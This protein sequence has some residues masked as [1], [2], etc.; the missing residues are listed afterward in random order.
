MSLDRIRKKID[1]LLNERTDLALE[2]GKL[3]REKES[4]VY[5]PH[6]ESEIYRKIDSLKEGSLPKDALKAIYRILPLD[7]LA[8]SSSECFRDKK[9][10]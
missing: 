2:I 3:K 6:R 9:R 4:E 10:L 8:R 1:S 5:A 7:K